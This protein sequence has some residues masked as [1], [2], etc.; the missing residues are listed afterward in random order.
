M[1]LF[2]TSHGLNACPDMV[3]FR[4]EFPQIFLAL[5]HAQTQRRLFTT[6]RAMLKLDWETLSIDPSRAKI[7]DAAINARSRGHLL[8]QPRYQRELDTQ[9]QSFLV[10]S[11]GRDVSHTTCGFSATQQSISARRLLCTTT[12]ARA[13]TTHT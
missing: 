2:S 8:T 5:G 10:Q 13:R 4:L 12:L 3:P 7:L 11:V 6:R 9:L 1:L